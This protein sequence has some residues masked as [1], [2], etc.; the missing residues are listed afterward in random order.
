MKK[1]ALVKPEQITEKEFNDFINE[2]KAAEESLVPY[3][4]DQRGKNF[5]AFVQAL[6]DEARGVLVFPKDGCR[7]QHTSWLMRTAE[8][9]VR[10]I[11]VTS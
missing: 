9:T 7:P 1:T 6:E 10:Q 11:S 4:I 2:F 8:F 3:S 5:S